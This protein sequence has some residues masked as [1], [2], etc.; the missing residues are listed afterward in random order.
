MDIVP[1]SEP[2]GSDQ[3][4]AQLMNSRLS[5]VPSAIK[6]N[7]NVNGETRQDVVMGKVE[8]ECAPP[9][10]DDGD[11]DDD[12]PLAVMSRKQ[13]KAKAGPKAVNQRKGKAPQKTIHTALSTK[14]NVKVRQ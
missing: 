3:R 8:S 2:L 7:N 14:Q 10:E 11:E 5:R 4:H 13:S 1:D 12:V 6:S 9:S